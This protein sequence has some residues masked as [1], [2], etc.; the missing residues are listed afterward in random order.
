M[1]LSDIKLQQINET[2]YK[3]IGGTYLDSL[4]R[5]NNHFYFFRIS[6]PIN[7]DNF[8]DLSIYLISGRYKKPNETTFI[9]GI[10]IISK[11]IPLYVRLNDL[12]NVSNDQLINADSLEL[13]LKKDES[14]PGWAYLNFGLRRGAV[15]TKYAIIPFDHRGIVKMIFDEQTLT[16]INRIIKEDNQE[17]KEIRCRGIW[18]PKGYLSRVKAA[19]QD[20][21][22][23]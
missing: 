1:Y 15:I 5:K 11:K 7:F 21:L 22:S 8:R 9:P 18:S 13:K 17:E 20:P 4:R 6:K 23:Q 2:E 16:E 19:A 10:S 14:M 12:A 3:L